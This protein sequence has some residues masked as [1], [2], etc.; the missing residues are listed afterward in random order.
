MKLNAYNT[1]ARFYD[2]TKRMVFGR[3]LDKAGVYYVNEW[4]E[5]QNVLII[6]G[7]TGQ[8]LHDL[9]PHSNITYVEASSE[10]IRLAR[11]RP[12]PC[13]V[14]FVH[15]DILDFQTDEKYDLVLLNFF[16]DL[17]TEDEI[18]R[19]LKHI[20]PFIHPDTQIVITDFKPIEEQ[21]SR[22]KRLVLRST[23]LFFAF[24]TGHRHKRVFNIRNA[25]KHANYQQV[26][27]KDCALG[28]VF[29]SIW[30]TDVY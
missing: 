25:V 17:F 20:R 11:K 4:R 7:G 9:S 18:T 19:Q 30:K 2:F 1:V 8:I 24:T 15:S 12:V 26:K 23:L 10:M 22:W 14:S 28:M 16:L 6:G 3:T 29:A 27:S 5:L 13:Q 21:D